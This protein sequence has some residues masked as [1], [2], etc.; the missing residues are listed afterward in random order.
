MFLV[1]KLDGVNMSENIVMAYIFMCY[2][3][4]IRRTLLQCFSKYRVSQI[5][6]YKRQ[7]FM[8][9]DLQSSKVQLNIICVILEDKIMT[10]KLP[11]K[12]SPLKHLFQIAPLI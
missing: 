5:Q 11:F 4:F 6:R 2:L 8:C 9:S 7:C 1:L 3:D 10:N 12:T